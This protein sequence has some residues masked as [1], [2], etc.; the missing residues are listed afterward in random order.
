M[1]Y[2]ILFLS[3]LS[4]FG[5]FANPVP[6]GKL[7]IYLDQTLQQNGIQ[8]FDVKIEKADYS[9][10]TLSKKADCDAVGHQLTNYS[11]AEGIYNVKITGLFEDGRKFQENEIVKV[12]ANEC[13]FMSVQHLE[14]TRQGKFV[15]YLDKSM[16]VN[17]REIR[18]IKVTIDGKYTGNLSSRFEA[19]PN[20]GVSGTVSKT[21][22]FGT[23]EIEI[24]GINDKLPTTNPHH[25]WKRTAKVKIDSEDGVAFMPISND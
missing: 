13:S 14:D 23:Y 24:T 9:K 8:S 2:F 3:T 1:K 25:F 6:K 15:M 5:A 16:K 18:D 4:Y 19:T 17:G 11:L 22:P 10:V 21:L 20:Y 7:V 12:A